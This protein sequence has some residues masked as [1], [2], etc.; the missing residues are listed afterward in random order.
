PPPRTER[1]KPPTP[2][3]K[4]FLVCRQILQG[5]LAP[6]FSLIGLTR[7]L[8]SPTFPASQPLGIFARLTSGH[9]AYQMEVQLQAMEGEVAWKGGPPGRGGMEAPLQAY[10]L[11]LKTL[12]P[13][14]PRPGV[15][16]LVLLA[17]GT[18][19]AR[20]KF[21]AHQAPPAG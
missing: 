18:E 5:P 20:D 3:C 4:S 19:I 14:C 15:Y 21:F 10:D 8:T 1:R 13:V 11:L 2:L 9:G 17:D 12:S 7:H 16:D 6:E